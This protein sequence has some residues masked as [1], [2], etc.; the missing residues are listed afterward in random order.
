[1]SCHVSIQRHQ[2]SCVAKGIVPTFSADPQVH[3]LG[4]KSKQIATAVRVHD[5][6]GYQCVPTVLVLESHWGCE[7]DSLA[8]LLLNCQVL[9]LADLQ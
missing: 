4:S 8:V 9:A 2:I 3:T 1:M 6:G 5:Q 7:L